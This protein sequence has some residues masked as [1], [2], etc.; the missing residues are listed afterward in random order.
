MPKPVLV[1]VDDE[2]D[3][4]Q[5]LTHELE[6]RYGAPHRVAS[7]PSPEAALIRPW[8]KARSPSASCTSTLHLRA[9]CM[10][11]PRRSTWSA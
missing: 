2:G 6:S 4:L 9:P 8:A 5:A 10:K 1:V 3:S 7:I 11:V